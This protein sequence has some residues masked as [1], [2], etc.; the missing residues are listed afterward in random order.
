[1]LR[2][3]FPY[4]QALVQVPLSHQ[5]AKSN[6]VPKKEKKE[7]FGLEADTKITC[8]TPPCRLLILPTPPTTFNHIGKKSQND[9]PCPSS[10]GGLGGKQDQGHG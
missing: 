7:G 10:Q 6:K 1:M 8:V 2:L 9:P 3:L 4:C 5:T